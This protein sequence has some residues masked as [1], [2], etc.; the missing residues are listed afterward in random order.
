MLY[1]ITLHEI[2]HVIGIG[3]NWGSNFI[4]NITHMMLKIAIVIK[5]IILYK[6]S[7]RI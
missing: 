6:W 4:M 2:G 1:F 3:S 5:D 7:K